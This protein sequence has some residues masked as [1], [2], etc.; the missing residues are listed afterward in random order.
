MKIYGLTALVPL[1]K[2]YSLSPLGE[3]QKSS[4]PM[5]ARFTSFDFGTDM[6]RA[7]TEMSLKGGCLL[8]G[9]L[10]RDLHNESRAGHTKTSQKTRW[11]CLDLD[12]VASWSSL[13]DFLNSINCGGVDYVVQWSNSSGLVPG[14]RCHLFLLLEKRLRPN[15]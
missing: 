10:D 3:V 15:S 13:D 7:I 6:T 8:K 2:N 14:L 9:E 4:Y 12:G 5:A 1:V 11:I